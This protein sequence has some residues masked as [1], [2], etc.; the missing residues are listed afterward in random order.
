MLICV[1]VTPKAARL[2]AIAFEY[3]VKHCPLAHKV[4]VVCV[5]AL[6][7]VDK[8]AVLKKLWLACAASIIPAYIYAYII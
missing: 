2:E 4:V 3:M 1:S 6:N 7:R 8:P 5:M